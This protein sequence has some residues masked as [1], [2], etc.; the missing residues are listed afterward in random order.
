MSTRYPSRQ[1]V[2]QKIQP[3]LDWIK[4]HTI[5]AEYEAPS[6]RPINYQE[7]VGEKGMRVPRFPGSA[8]H[9]NG[10]DQPQLFHEH[11][12]FVKDL[13]EHPT[14]GLKR[15]YDRLNWGIAKGNRILSDLKALGYVVVKELKSSN[16]HGG[17][18]RLVPKLTAQ[19]EDYLKTYGT[20]E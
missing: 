5:Y 15:R 19:G 2:L 18:S 10:A 13:G 20:R 12:V 17:R 4:Q 7:V 6:T 8:S 11:F 14:D 9:R 16:P 3:E 1:E